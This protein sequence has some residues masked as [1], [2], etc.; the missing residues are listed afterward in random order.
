MHL[1][2]VWN[3]LSP[4]SNELYNPTTFYKDFLIKI[5][6]TNRLERRN[7]EFRMNIVILVILA[8][9]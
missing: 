3:P 9:K 7:E 2:K 4:L 1:G 6:E 8:L 5:K